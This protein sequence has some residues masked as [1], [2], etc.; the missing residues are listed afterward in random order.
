MQFGHPPPHQRDTEH[1]ADE[2]G[3]HRRQGSTFDAH[4]EAADEGDDQEHVEDRGDDQ[5]VERRAAVTQR[6]NH[7]A[8]IVEGDGG[9]GA[10]KEH[11]E[12][13]RRVLHQLWRRPEEFEERG[14]AERTDE[15]D[16]DGD[17]EA[18]QRP[19]GDAASHAC[20][21]ARPKVSSDGDRQT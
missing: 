2:L 6:A 7:G 16:H 19:G 1:H 10:C 11:D 9:Q 21:V 18:D 5:E 4:S 12:E 14:C 3:H 20:H 13:Q 8:Q 15:R 17:G